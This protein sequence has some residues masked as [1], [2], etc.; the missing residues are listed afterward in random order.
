[1]QERARVAID[2]G[3]ESCRV[4]LLRWQ[5]V[6][7]SIQVVHRIPNGPVHRVG[8]LHWPIDN[9]LDGIEEGLRRAAAVA[10]EGIA[11]IAVDCWSVDYVRLASDGSILRE[12]FCY[13]DERTVVTKENAD[14]IIAPL[15]LYARTGA[16]PQRINTVYQLMADADA[17]IEAAA[18]WVMLPEY[19]LY[20]LSG[21]RVAEYTNASHTG[22]VSLKTRD[23][24]AEVF[25]KLGLE[26]SAAPQIVRAGTVLGVLRGKLAELDAF[27]NTEIIAPATH[28]TASAIAGIAASLDRGAYISSGTWSLVGTLT[29]TPVTTQQ[30]LDAGYTNIGAA[31][32]ELLF[33]ALVNSMWVLKQ[34]MNAW[35]AQ[36]RDWEIEE[37]VARAA[38][39]DWD[40]SAVLDMD[41]PT[42]M[43]DS[44]MPG[45]IN[46]ELARLGIDQVAN[47][48]GNEPV[49]A[50]LIFES[51]AA[52]YAP[53]ISNLE[54][55]LGRKL[56]RIHMIGGATRNKL[57]IRFTEERTGLPVEIGECESATVGNFA[58]QLAAS[59]AGGA[60]I[61]KE[62]I[63]EQAKRLFGLI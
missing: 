14:G 39:C 30:A 52:R 35:S 42:L 34:C 54:A 3:A 33:H 63:R 13:R 17:G 23:W 25:A 32:G 27:Q 60:A 29:R 37:L 18:P 10:P 2:L 48:A 46:A 19:V 38:D 7:P 55:T 41:A 61:T 43:L 58:I 24:D 40:A 59:D 36:G 11:S 51:L 9:I 45:R 28:D 16:H 44:D 5:G 12:P 62:A 1:M 8:E 57:L 6:R 47:V 4:S 50:R 49:F 31:T 56:E 26:A 21:K 53:A 22:L 20:W 15:D